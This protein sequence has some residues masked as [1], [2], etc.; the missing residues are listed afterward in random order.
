MRYNPVSTLGPSTFKVHDQDAVK[1]AW[2]TRY[3]L[4][5]LTNN[6]S[7]FCY[8]SPAHKG[9]LSQTSIVSKTFRQPYSI[10]TRIHVSSPVLNY[11][12][13]SN[14]SD[15]GLYCPYKHS[16]IN[17]WHRVSL[18]STARHT[19][20]TITSQSC[21]LHLAK[22]DTGTNHEA[23]TRREFRSIRCECRHFA[24]SVRP[25]ATVCES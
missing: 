10:Y 14:C 22:P 15:S 1:A 2:T 9:E 8:P 7:S 18:S 23:K 4:T 13:F 19:P 5:T 11:S 17:R 3:D 25:G 6:T 12:H 24:R 21:H 16:Y 20:L